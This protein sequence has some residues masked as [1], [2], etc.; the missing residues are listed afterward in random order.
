[1]IDGVSRYVALWSSADD[2]PTVETVRPGDVL[3]LPGTSMHSSARSDPP[4]TSSDLG[5]R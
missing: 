2:V 4:V 1:V 3:A 5:A